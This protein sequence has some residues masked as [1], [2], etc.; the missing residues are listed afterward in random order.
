MW[1]YKVENLQSFPLVTLGWVC[2]ST[3]VIV[4]SWVIVLDV[5]KYPVLFFHLSYI[6]VIC[7]P[8]DPDFAELVSLQLWLPVMQR[9]ASWD[10]SGFLS[11]LWWRKKRKSNIYIPA[12]YLMFRPPSACLAAMLG[13]PCSSCCWAATK[14]FHCSWCLS[15]SNRIAQLRSHLTI[16]KSSSICNSESQQTVCVG[17]WNGLEMLC[18]WYIFKPGVKSQHSW[19]SEC[20]GKSWHGAYTNYH[21]K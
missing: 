1:K 10:A 8:A 21:C 20:K 15:H 6:H 3:L 5:Q 13:F 11:L 12:V 19:V 2:V 7:F 4:G 14:L 17:R 18:L 16:W 9:W